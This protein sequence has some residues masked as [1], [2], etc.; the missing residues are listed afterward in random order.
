MSTLIGHYKREARRLKLEGCDDGSRGGVM[1]FEGG[2]G[3]WEG[4]KGE[5]EG[6]E[7]GRSQLR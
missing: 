1:C 4:G 3:G 6:K 7:E 2:K 5:R